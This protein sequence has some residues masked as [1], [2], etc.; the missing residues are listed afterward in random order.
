MEIPSELRTTGAHAVVRNNRRMLRDGQ[1]RPHLGAFPRVQWRRGRINYASVIGVWLML[2]VLFCSVMPLLVRHHYLE[3]RRLDDLQ[4]NGMVIQAT[5]DHRYTRENDGTEY[6]VRYGYRAGS[7]AISREETVS[8]EFYESVTVG[9]PVNIKA[10]PDDWEYARLVEGPDNDVIKL[11][12]RSVNRVLSIAVTLALPGLV[13][14]AGGGVLLHKL[15]FGPFLNSRQ[16]ALRL[17]REG[18]LL[19]GEITNIVSEGVWAVVHYRF[20]APGGGE[21]KGATA[22]RREPRWERDEFPVG[23][24]VLVLYVDDELHTVL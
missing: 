23:T 12:G 18:Q 3:I 7:R 20:T 2:C 4:N 16:R 19:P 9:T 22:P 15:V 24:P 11:N 1:G 10:D 21:I 8:A 13:I 14:L 5:I 17:R 6:V